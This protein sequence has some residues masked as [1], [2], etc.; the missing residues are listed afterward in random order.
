[1]KRINKDL[2]RE[3]IKGDNPTTDD[4]PHK[5]GKVFARYRFTKLIKTGNL[6]GYFKEEWSTLDE[7]KRQKNKKKER[8]TRIG[9]KEINPKTEEFWKRGEICDKRGIFWEYSRDVKDD[10]FYTCIFFDEYTKY[11]QERIKTIFMKRRIVAKKNNL[12]FALDYNYLFD[13]FPKD[14]LCPILGIKMEWT[15]IRNA[16]ENPSLDRIKPELGYVKGNVIWVSYRG[17][18]LKNN[19]SIEELEML[20]DYLKKKK[21]KKLKI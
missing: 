11:H 13:I 8:Y 18:M 6:K 3:Y 9:K 2:N 20:I 10:G 7:L 21:W 19:A 17:N 1:M 5:E 12:P 16:S 15:H 4:L 14:Y